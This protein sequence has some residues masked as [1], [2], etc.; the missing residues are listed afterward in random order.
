M[1]KTRNSWLQFVDLSV[2]Q[3]L[4]EHALKYIYNKISKLLPSIM[5]NQ[6]LFE[7]DSAYV[8]ATVYRLYNTT[9]DWFHLKV[10]QLATFLTP[11][12]K[13]S[14][15]YTDHNKLADGLKKGT[16]SNQ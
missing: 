9:L 6:V 3:N 16:L 5:L 7:W 1:Y 15:L 12:P 10:E 11:N 2:S 4:E 13:V 8:L 14:V